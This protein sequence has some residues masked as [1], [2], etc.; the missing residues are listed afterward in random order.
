MALELFTVESLATMDGG[1]IKVAMEAAL[2]RLVA[3]CRDRPADDRARK[4]TLTIALAPVSDD[5]GQLS[6]LQVTFDIGESIP[7][8]RSKAY[9]MGA[10]RG[11]LL[12]N[13]LSH[14]DVRQGTLDQL[15]PRVVGGA[16]GAPGEAADAA[17]AH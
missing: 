4:L 16:G 14:D 8:M 2:A 15:K 17:A 13:D 7:K 10:A 6:E 11:G 1:R 5:G 3:D 12:F 9:S